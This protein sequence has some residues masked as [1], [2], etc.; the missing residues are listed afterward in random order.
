MIKN[1]QFV[2]WFSVFVR[3][4]EANLA[5]WHRDNEEKRFEVMLNTLKTYSKM[6][7]DRV[8]LNILLDDAYAHRKSEIDDL[9]KSHF[10]CP[11]DYEEDRYTLKTQLLSRFEKVKEGMSDKD[12]IFFTQNDDHPFIDFNNDI[13]IEGLNHMG[14]DEH[15]YKSMYVSHWPEIIRVSMKQKEDQQIGNFIKF[16]GILCD[17]IQIFNVGYVRKILQDLIPDDTAVNGYRIDCAIEG[18]DIF[19]GKGGVKANIYAPLRELCLHFDGYGHCLI[20]YSIYPHLRIP[21]ENNHLKF[22][23]EELIL[24]MTVPA[25]GWSV[26]DTGGEIKYQDPFT[27]IPQKY[28]DTM[29]K[30]YN[31]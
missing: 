25:Q 16:N 23:K 30:C 29:L 13:L 17:S 18:K 12:L 11:V 24:R 14:E 4:L 15:P 21:F 2:L 26:I 27:P 8:Y 7:F 19:E 6:P 10:N 3:P 28:I 22:S 9:I 1:N 5:P 20:P 31:I